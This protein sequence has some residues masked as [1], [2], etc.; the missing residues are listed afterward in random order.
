MS[1]ECLAELGVECAVDGRVGE[2]EPVGV[3]VDAG[4][5]QVGQ[6]AEER[7]VVHAEPFARAV[8]VDGAGLAV[9]AVIG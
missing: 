1:D 3:R 7:V 2:S 8:P 4:E 9:I 6:R 5:G